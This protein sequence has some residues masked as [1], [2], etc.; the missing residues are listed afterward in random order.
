MSYR[1]PKAA[2]INTGAAVYKGINKL[3]GDVL[4]FANKERDRKGQLIADSLADSQAV[5]DNINKAGIKTSKDGSTGL[6]NQLSI[7]SIEVKN[8]MGAQ[9]DILNKTFSSPAARAKAKAE[10]ARLKKYP[11][12]LAGEMATGQYL[13]D[14]WNESR[15]KKNGT[16]GS[17]SLS[18][19]LDVMGV[20]KDLQSG[21]SN[22]TIEDKDGGRVLV[23]TSKGETFKLN[24]SDITQGLKANP[25]QSLFKKVVDDKADVDMYM[26]QL[27]FGKGVTKETLIDNGHLKSLGKRTIAGKEVEVFGIDNKRLATAAKELSN[28]LVDDS[29]NY[30]YASSVW[31]DHMGENGTVTE[32][33]EATSREEV[34][35]KIQDHYIKKATKQAELNLG[36]TL[37]LPKPTAPEKATKATAAE[38]KQKKYNELVGRLKG[39]AKKGGFFDKFTEAANKHL[40]G[41]YTQKKKDEDLRELLGERG[42][43]ILPIY[44]TKNELIEDVQMIKDKNTG[45]SIE[46]SADR[47]S[48]KELMDAVLVM[49][50]IELPDIQDITRDPLAP[51]KI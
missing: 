16:I 42:L 34:L 2:P 49:Q 19:D 4:S 29:D 40:H 11:E 17:I 36:F 31:Q 20:I 28:D 8:K 7:K 3:A 41:N 10:I 26:S 18:N 44:D 21:G 13:V 6:G 50:G 27:G 22:T 15:G 33:I 39:D 38:I 51:I 46:I 47:I 37:G 12:E 9:Y 24:I 48:K 14:Q 45:K 5:D 30:V 23:T 25:N 32:A 1:N 43:S 35:G